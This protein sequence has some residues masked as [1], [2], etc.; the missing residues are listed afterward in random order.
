MTANHKGIFEFRICN[1]DKLSG[2]VT[3]ECLNKTVLKIRDTDETQF[4][5]DNKMKQVYTIQLPDDLVCEH[6]VL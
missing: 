2:D 4:I 3:Q 6:C 1:L 5:I